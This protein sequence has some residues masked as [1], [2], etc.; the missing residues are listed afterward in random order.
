VVMPD[1]PTPIK[2]KTHTSEPVPYL[3]YSSAEPTYGGLV[4]NEENA[5]ESGVYYDKG[6]AIAQKLFR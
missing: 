1:H 5:K 6:I 3:Y 4:Y 2:L